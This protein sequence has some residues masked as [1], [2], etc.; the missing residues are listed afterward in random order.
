MEAAQGEKEQASQAKEA[1]T[2]ELQTRVGELEE[3]LAGKEDES[4]AWVAAALPSGEWLEERIA[5]WELIAS[6]DVVGQARQ[7]QDLLGGQSLRGEAADEALGQW[8]ALQDAVHESVA[9]RVETQ[10]AELEQLKSEG[11][12]AAQS[13]ADDAEAKVAQS[14]GAL[15]EAQEALDALKA[16]HEQSQQEVTSLEEQLQTAKRG[17]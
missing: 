15:T 10:A 9:A 1:A 11:E 2:D 5:N 4:A 14:A 8:R 17:D 6:E 3:A 16:E 7:L 12:L 13:L